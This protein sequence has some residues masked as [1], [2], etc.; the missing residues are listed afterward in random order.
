MRVD[1]IAQNGI[2][3]LGN[4]GATIK[5]NTISG[6]R[7]TGPADTYATGILN[8]DVAGSR[9]AV[10]GN[11]FVNTQ[12]HIDGTVAVNVHGTSAITV[13]PHAVRVDL[14]SAA[15]PV[16]TVLGTKL[17]WKVKVDGRVTFHTKQGFGDHDVYR[18]PFATGSGRH[19]IQVIKNGVVVRNRVV[20]F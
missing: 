8:V 3:I 16:N 5:D 7:Y 11:T 14:R 6:L 17:D 19:V 4:A 20:H 10:S 1:Y 12:V 15:Q 2:V 18:A 13:R 9:I